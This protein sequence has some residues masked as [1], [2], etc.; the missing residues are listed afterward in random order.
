MYVGLY[1]LRITYPRNQRSVFAAGHPLTRGHIASWKSE[2]VFS[3]EKLRLSV[4][5]QTQVNIVKPIPGSQQIISQA[6]TET[7]EGI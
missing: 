2:P 1:S 7:F 6:D 4:I 5:T 3:E